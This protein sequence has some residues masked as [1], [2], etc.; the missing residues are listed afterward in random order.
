MTNKQ[1]PRGDFLEG[2]FACTRAPH[3]QCVFLL[4]RRMTND[5]W[6]AAAKRKIM[7]G[8]VRQIRRRRLHKPQIGRPVAGNRRKAIAPILSCQPFETHAAGGPTG[9]SVDPGART[10]SVRH[11]LRLRRGVGTAHLPW[12]VRNR[13]LN[14]VP[15]APSV[16]VANGR[17][18]GPGTAPAVRSSVRRFLPARLQGWGGWRASAPR[19]P[20]P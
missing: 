14:P 17:G 11:L 13:G 7:K 1:E 15:P 18:P 10:R 8:S 12:G 16:N 20:L 4:M 2:P 6:T 3:A 5:G 19:I 9:R